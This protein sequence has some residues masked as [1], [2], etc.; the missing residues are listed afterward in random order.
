MT[1]LVLML[2]GVVVG[3]AAV[4]SALYG[5]RVLYGIVGAEFIFFGIVP[6]AALFVSWVILARL[7]KLGKMSMFAISACIA[8]AGL[9]VGMFISLNTWGS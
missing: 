3:E 2:F 7:A 6:I 5:T 9:W 1:R 8:F 4:L